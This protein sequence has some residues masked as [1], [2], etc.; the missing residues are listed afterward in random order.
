MNFNFRVECNAFQFLCIPYSNKSYSTK[1]E[2][3]KII[4]KPVIFI[5]PVFENNACLISLQLH[6]NKLMEL[7]FIVVIYCSNTCS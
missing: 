4:S 3:L 6:K 7:S 5:W 1:I 2:I